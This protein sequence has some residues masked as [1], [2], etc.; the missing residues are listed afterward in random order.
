MRHTA[1]YLTVCTLAALV[2]LLPMH[3]K[4][5]QGAITQ[6]AFSGWPEKLE[7]QVLTPQPLADYEVRF[8]GDFPGKIGRF[9]D[10]RRE[11]TIRWVTE[12]TRKLHSASE[13]LESSGFRIGPLPL[14]VDGNGSLWSSFVATRGKQR[15]RVR[16]RIYSASGESWPDV[17]SWYWAAERESSAG[18]WWA[19]TVAE[20]EPEV[21]P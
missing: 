7:G 11:V 10:G 12:T 16:E 1:L 15:L 2:P 17:S 14:H 3:S 4:R 13:C 20:V 6:V 8:G 21:K 5:A 18:P 19:I 9:S